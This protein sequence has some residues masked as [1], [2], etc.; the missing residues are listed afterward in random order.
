MSECWRGSVELDEWRREQE[1]WRGGEMR[2]W[3]RVAGDG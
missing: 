1:V 3:W 2:W